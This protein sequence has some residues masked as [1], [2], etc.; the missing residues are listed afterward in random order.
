VT[1]LTAADHLCEARRKHRDAMRFACEF[2]EVSDLLGCLS[3]FAEWTTA[4][5]IGMESTALE[6]GLSLRR[7]VTERCIERWGAPGEE[8]FGPLSRALHQ[9]QG[10]LWTAA[11]VVTAEVLAAGLRVQQEVEIARWTDSA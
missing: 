1:V 3:A 6:I 11:G 5:E 8:R 7:R 9:L 4:T 10:A 2:W